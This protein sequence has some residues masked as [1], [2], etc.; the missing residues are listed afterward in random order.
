MPRARHDVCGRLRDVLR[1]EEG[2]VTFYGLLAKRCVIP[3]IRRI[4]RR[5]A[6]EEQGHVDKMREHILSVCKAASEADPA[7]DEEDRY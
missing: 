3:G 4:F 2:T 6:E 7:V 1:M 5:I